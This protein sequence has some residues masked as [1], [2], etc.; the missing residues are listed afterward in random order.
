MNAPAFAD[1]FKMFGDMKTPAIDFNQIFTISR[2][3]VEALTAANQVVMEGFQA[4]SRR[5]A[6][7]ARSNF[8]QAIKTG[9]DAFSGTTPDVAATK[10]AEAAKHM[11][12][13]SFHN[14]REAFE[15]MTK[16]NLEAFDLL[17]KRMA[18]SIEEGTEAATTAAKK[19][20]K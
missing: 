5:Q 13:K 8:E 9:R 15:M 17:N 20:K 6:E 7:I 18:E 14:I 2:R 11:F 16:S 3:N 19:A 4:V 12:E 10:Q 1:M